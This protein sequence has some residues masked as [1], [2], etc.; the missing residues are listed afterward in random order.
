MNT[1][2]RTLI[3]RHASHFGLTGCPCDH[4]GV[5]T[6]LGDKARSR[7]L[8]AGAAAIAVVIMH[9][10][11]AMS[12]A[13]AH[14]CGE[15]PQAQHLMA[16]PT[17]GPEMAAHDLAKNVVSMGI[18]QIPSP[19]DSPFSSMCIAILLAGFVFTLT[20]RAYKVKVLGLGPKNCPT[21]PPV[22]DRAPPGVDLN[23]ICV[24]RT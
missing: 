7:V 19:I 20:S 2:I 24:L 14:A 11:V 3:S 16:S 6:V 17:V 1:V 13:S 5:F 12:P 8:L 15:I 23:E 4:I 22:G 21:L 18:A 9:G 10:L